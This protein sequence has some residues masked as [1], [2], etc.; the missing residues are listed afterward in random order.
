MRKKKGNPG[1]EREIVNL[2]EASREVRS[3]EL[4][5]L[6][7][8]KTPS[9]QVRETMGNVSYQTITNLRNQPEYT[10]T[11]E[12]LRAEWMETVR[13]TPGGVELR[14]K[15]SYGMVLS[16]DRLIEII[17]PDTRA[18]IKDRI[19]AARLMAQLDGRFLHDTEGGETTSKNV[20]SVANELL[21]AINKQVVQ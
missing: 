9:S 19:S 8:A 7:W 11:L 6:D 18:A 12:M 16:L 15:I 4:A 2:S 3:R 17:V 10:E 21:A 13:R 1:V 20:D 14:Q 5:V